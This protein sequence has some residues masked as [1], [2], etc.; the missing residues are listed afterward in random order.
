VHEGRSHFQPSTGRNFD[1]PTPLDGAMAKNYLAQVEQDAR[2]LRL[3]LRDTDRVPSWV[4]VYVYTAA[5][6]M[7]T[8]S[9]YMEQRMAR[10]EPSESSSSSGYA[11]PWTDNARNVLQ[12]SPGYFLTWYTAKSLALVAAVAVAAYY[13]GKNSALLLNPNVN[14]NLNPNTN[15]MQ[16]S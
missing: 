1:Y 11:G 15:R 8:A 16:L 13:A 5:D 10:F 2:R 4:N 7:Q 9:R 12:N 3:A 14:P 6:R